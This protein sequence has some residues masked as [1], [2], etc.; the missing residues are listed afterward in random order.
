MTKTIGPPVKPEG[1]GYMPLSQAAYWIATNG[2]TK[3]VDVDDQAAWKHAY[4]E[5]LA[6]ITSNDVQIIGQSND[7]MNEEIN[8]L[9]FAGLRVSYPYHDTPSEL[10][11]GSEPYIESWPFI[12][13]EHWRKGF[14]DKLV[15]PRGGKRRWS[16]LQVK[17][18]DVRRIWRFAGDPDASINSGLVRPNSRRGRPPKIEWGAVRDFVHK[19]L[20]YHGLPQSGDSQWSCQADVERAVTKFIE[21]RFGTSMAVSTIRQYTGKFIT[22]W[23]RWKSR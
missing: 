3:S 9:L 5:L 1:G 23:L 14:N 4:D 22:E 8:A 7:G 13:D 18:E 12:D 10:L 20:E 19:K 6:H 2:G 16:R 17:K 21:K 15:P 11:F